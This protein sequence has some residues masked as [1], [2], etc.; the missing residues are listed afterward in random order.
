M[1]KLLGVFFLTVFFTGCATVEPYDYSALI[2]SKP[3]SILVLP[4][5]NESVDVKAPYIFLSTISRP[6]AEK[7]YYVFPVAVIDTFLKENGLPEPAEMHQVPLDKLR[8]NIGADA[9]FYVTINNWGQKYQ[10]ISSTTTV[11]ASARLV[12]ASSGETLWDTEIKLAQGSSDGGGGLAGAIVGAIVEQIVDTKFDQTVAVSLQASTLA[13]NNEKRGL[14]EGP[15]RKDS[16]E[17]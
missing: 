17:L 10:V 7:G 2:E 5:L 9:V 3:R 12:D 16:P 1:K 6:L 11:D 14:L 4:P 15:Y 13:V 8:E